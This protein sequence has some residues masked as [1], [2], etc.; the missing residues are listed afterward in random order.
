MTATNNY[1]AREVNYALASGLAAGLMTASG[2]GMA[3]EDSLL[4]PISAALISGVQ[5]LAYSTVS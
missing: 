4:S 1:Y 2:I 3:S 5:Y